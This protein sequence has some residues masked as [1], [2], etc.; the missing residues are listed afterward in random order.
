MRISDWSSDVCSSDLGHWPNGFTPTSTDRYYRRKRRYRRRQGCRGLR[1]NLPLILNMLR[2]AII[3]VVLG[4]FYVPW[5]Y[6][7]QIATVLYAAAAI[8]D[9]FDGYLARRCNQ[10]TRFGAFLDPVADKLLEIGKA[11][12]RERGCLYV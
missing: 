7:R 6:A 1:L 5:E 9:W 2:V 11:S 4:L 3:P 10:T 12:C 8:T